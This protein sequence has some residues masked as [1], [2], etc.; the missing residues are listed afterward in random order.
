MDKASGILGSLNSCAPGSVAANRGYVVC[1]VTF[2]I[3]NERN[4][5]RPP[6]EVTAGFQVSGFGIGFQG[7]GSRVS[8]LVFRLDSMYK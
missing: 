2:E 1:H 3:P 5:R 7:F 4:P 6:C 8:D